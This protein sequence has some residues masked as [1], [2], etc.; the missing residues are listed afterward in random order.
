M[1][2][3]PPHTV[4]ELVSV[5]IP[6]F[7]QERYIDETIQSVLN[8][9]WPNIELIIIDD[10][11]KDGSRTVLESFGERL[12]ILEHPGRVNKGQSAAINL[13]LRQSRGEYLGILDSD[14]L[15]VP[16]KI[17]KQMR[18]LENN[19]D[20]GLVYSNGMY[21]DEN[22]KEVCKML[23]GNHSPPSGP[24][25]VLLSSCYNV[26]SNSLF[27]RS[28]FDKVGFLDESLRSAQDHDYAIR[29]AEVTR[30]GYIDECLWKYRRHGGSISNNRTMERWK[31]GFKIL[32]AARK[33]HPYPVS[34]IRQRKA[35]LNAR[36]GQCYLQEKRYFWAGYH[37]LLAGL[38]DPLRS[39]RV[40]TGREIVTGPQ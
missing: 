21:I 16:D 36:L 10:G 2:N 19:P 38:L 35:I 23:Y 39:L 33:R 30:I 11:C 13:G 29:I 17:E 18:F 22:G 37:L 4:A 1:T 8:Q 3:I 28:V 12:T 5:V 25:Q 14:D 15:F 20:F 7:N 27:R 9:T 24:E 40:I 26:P 34:T 6:C 32:E 31:N